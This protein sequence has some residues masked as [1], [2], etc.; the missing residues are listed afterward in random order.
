M[1]LHERTAIADDIDLVTV[2]DLNLRLSAHGVCKR[3]VR[4][5]ITKRRIAG[6]RF[7]P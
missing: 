6:T 3:K 1:S 2:G 7:L 5:S 4:F